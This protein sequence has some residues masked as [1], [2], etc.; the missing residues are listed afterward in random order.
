M[1]SLR[2]RRPLPNAEHTLARAKREAEKFRSRF[3]GDANIGS[4]TLRTPLGT[5]E[6]DYTVTLGVIEFVIHKKP[7]VVPAMLIEKI[8]DQ[9]L[10]SG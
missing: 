10:Q 6:G 3:D 7:M 8:L 2:I 5:L 4:Y 1:K 9:F